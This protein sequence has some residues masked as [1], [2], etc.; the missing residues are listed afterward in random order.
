[1]AISLWSF[2]FPD[3]ASLAK[4]P[5]GPSSLQISYQDGRGI[6]REVLACCT[7]SEFA[8]SRV[9]VERDPAHE[10]GA[11]RGLGL[12]ALSP[13][14]GVESNSAPPPRASSRFGLRFGREV[15]RPPRR[16]P[17]RDPRRDV[18]SSR[19]T[20]TS[21]PTERGHEMS[22]F[23][24]AAARLAN[25]ATIAFSSGSRMSAMAFSGSTH[26]TTR[27]PCSGQVALCL[28][29]SRGKILTS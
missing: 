27:C 24:A 3:R 4:I 2:I 15:C 28:R 18:G 22:L 1:M 19:A 26:W 11:G 9:Q 12:D 21:S 10:V 7:G 23:A 13:D 14:E 17:E 8:V 5:L 29:T 20:A 25:F 6:L 16:A